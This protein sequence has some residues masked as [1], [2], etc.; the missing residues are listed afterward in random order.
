MRDRGRDHETKPFDGRNGEGLLARLRKGVFW[1]VILSDTI[2]S[3]DGFRKST[4]PQNCQ[5]LVLIRDSKQ[6]FDD[7][8]G[9]LTF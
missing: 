7:F 1:N 8:V 5:L 9:E 6:Q 4:P 2:Y 3:L